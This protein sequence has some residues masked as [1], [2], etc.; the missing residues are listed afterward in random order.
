MNITFVAVKKTSMRECK[1]Q[2]R[3]ENLTKERLQELASQ[4]GH[5]VYEHVYDV[6]FEPFSRARVETCVRRLVQIARSSANQ[7][8]AKGKA[9]E[10]SELLQFSECYQTMFDRLCNPSI[11][12]N[13][14]HVQTIYAMIDVHDCMRRGMIG[15]SEARG[16]ASNIALAGLM[17]QTKLEPTPPETVIEELDD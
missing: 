1:M 4:E 5:E 2:R 13:Q 15:E 6:K 10:D 16:Q 14:S 8:E 9:L 12:G 3:V 11:S 17:R 7:A